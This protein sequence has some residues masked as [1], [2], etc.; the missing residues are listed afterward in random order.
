ME[1]IVQ[2]SPVG[3]FFRALWNTFKP[4]DPNPQTHRRKPTAIERLEWTTHNM[5]KIARAQQL[6]PLGNRKPSSCICLVGQGD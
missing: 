2:A 6:T 1:A 4:T 5:Q 3:A